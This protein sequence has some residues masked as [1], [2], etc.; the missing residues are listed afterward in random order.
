MVR[1]GKVRPTMSHEEPEVQ[2]SSFFNLGIRWRMVANAT[3]RLLHPRKRLSTPRIGG[4]V[5]PRAGLEGCGKSRPPPGFDPR[6][7]Q[8]VV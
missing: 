7:V 4:W 8:P 6:T 1:K 5:S 2:L 3:P